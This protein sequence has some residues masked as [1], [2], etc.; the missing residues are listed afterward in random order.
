[1]MD[2]IF[3]IANVALDVARRD[4]ERIAVIQP[5]GNRQ[6]KKYTYRQL[7]ADAESV[8]PG[9]R[10]MGIA[11]RTRVVC[12]MPPSYETCVMSLALQRVGAMMVWIDPSVGYLNVGERLRRVDPEAF[13]GIRLAHLGRI[14]FGWGPRF[15]KK[16]VVLDAKVGFP[17]ARTLASLKR[18]APAEP[19]QPNV[20]PDDPALI[21]YTTGSTGPAKPA[22]YSHRNCVHMYRVVHESWRFTEDKVPV[23]IAIF[24]VFFSIALSAGGTVVVPPIDFARESPATADP[25]AILEV[26]QDCE[27]QSCFASPV[28]LENM[29][30]YAIEHGIKTPAFKRVIGGGAPIIAR[31]KERLL[32]M[33]GPEGQVFSN[34][35]ATEALPSTE[36]D[37]RE[38]LG[39]TWQKTLDG[40][41]LCVGRPFTGVELKIVRMKDGPIPTLRAA[42]ELPAGEIGEILVKGAHVSREYFQDEESTK[43]N[44]VAGNDGEIWH[45]LG[46]A[47]YLDEQGRLWYCGRVSQRVRGKDGP[48][49]SLNVEPIFDRHPGVRR[50]G[51]VGVPSGDAEIPVI[52]AELLPGTRELDKVR[53]DLLASAHAHST[54]SQIK[55][56]LFPKVL[57]VDPR[58]KSKIERPALAKWA[59]ANMHLSDAT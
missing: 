31:V 46:D 24:P 10:E 57:P 59:K 40:A 14:A 48:L 25:K 20:A 7:S 34:Y 13:V 35:G 23:D 17:G 55:H 9:L 6:Y 45:R 44:K 28:L 42:E 22:L 16:A 29:A 37:G 50:S 56:V 32:K 30:N 58:H 15:P 12:M 19:P 39:E 49:F 2:E 3:N 4:P 43:K 51:L 5:I 27:V 26:I 47:G 18:E 38:T 36:M 8:A 52:C 21:L 54:T 1:M 11:E 41:G 53:A 33:M